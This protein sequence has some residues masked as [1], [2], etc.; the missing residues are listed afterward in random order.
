M[1]KAL[2]SVLPGTAFAVAFACNSTPPVAA[3]ENCTLNSDCDTP[4]ICVFSRCHTACNDSGDC[5]MT[6]ERC[7]P[8]GGDAG[9]VNVCQ[10]PSEESCG[11]GSACAGNEIC[12][13]D[14]QCRASCQTSANC[15]GTQTCVTTGSV[16]ACFDPDNATDQAT[17]GENAAGADGGPSSS[18]ARASADVANAEGSLTDAPSTGDSTVDAPGTFAPNPDAALGFS[19]SNLGSATLDAGPGPN[20]DSSSADIVIAQTGDDSTL[21]PAP[22]MITMSDGTSAVLYVFNSFTVEQ[23]AALRFTGVLPV[24]VVVRGSVNIQG[25]V[26][27]NAINGAAGPGG[28]EGTNPGP[29]VGQNGVSAG[30]PNSGAGGGSFCGVGGAGAASSPPAA[31]GGATYGNAALVPLFGGSAGGLTNSASASAGPGGGGAIEIAAGEQIVI[32]EFGAINAGGGGSTLGWQGYFAGGS[33]GAILL[34]APSITVSGTLAAN[35]GG[36]G[37]LEGG[38]GGDATANTQPAPGYGGIGGNG[39]AGATVNGSSAVLVDG[40]SDFGSGGGGAGRIR[41]NTANGNATITGTV[42]P[43]LTTGCA[44]QGTLD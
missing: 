4:L 33:G 21:L 31:Q 29:G 43:A 14:K 17:L 18:D 24:I 16:G 1:G 34:E 26:L 5:P 10:L 22:E 19:V 9:G 35:G 39:S 32:G 37:E 8:A 25:Q 23:T 15:V 12:G 11:S 42:S 3:S 13:S 20:A 41:I 2:A 28:F 40:G 38:N 36:G 27:V 7:V 30:F 6:G 44:T